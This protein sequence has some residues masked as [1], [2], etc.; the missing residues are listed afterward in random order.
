M[1]TNPPT[2]S[3]TREPSK[4]PT[5]EPTTGDTDYSCPEK[6]T[7]SP[8]SDYTVITKGNAQIAAHSV[9]TSLWVG[10]QFS[11]P[12][13]QSG[14]AAGGH[15]Y[16]GSLSSVNAVSFNGGRTKISDLPSPDPTTWPVDFEFYEWLA[17]NIK[18]GSYS[19][20]F[21]VFVETTHRKGKG[22]CYKMTDFLDQK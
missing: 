4:K 12:V 15:V 16:Y 5:A 2:R 18:P 8:T 22:N 13:P 17:L 21:Q 20:G 14:V 3:P 1:P 9:Y 6:F 7:E 11:N 10:G 19:G